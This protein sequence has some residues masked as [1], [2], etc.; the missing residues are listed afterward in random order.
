MLRGCNFTAST[1]IASC[2]RPC[3][4]CLAR[5]GMS[6][7][8]DYFEI[9]LKS[10]SARREQYTVYSGTITRPP[11]DKPGILDATCALPPIRLPTS[12]LV[13]YA[14]PLVLIPF[15]R[16]SSPSKAFHLYRLR[17]FFFFFTVTICVT[18]CARRR[19][20]S[21]QVYSSAITAFRGD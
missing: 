6:N 19:V 4:H 10:L 2:N 11:T 5:V 15:L 18:I 14:A 21:I 1:E 20:P 9:V 3:N 12:M 7:V 8:P 13:A 16:T 17:F